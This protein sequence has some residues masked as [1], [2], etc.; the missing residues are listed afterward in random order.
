VLEPLAKAIPQA[1]RDASRPPAL[2]GLGSLLRAFFFN[3]DFRR[4]LAAVNSL[5]ET[6]GRSMSTNRH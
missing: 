5:L 1:L 4:G 3:Q 6:M 2:V